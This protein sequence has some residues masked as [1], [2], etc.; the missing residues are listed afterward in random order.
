MARKKQIVLDDI[1]V[2]TLPFLSRTI[3]G[4]YMLKAIEERMKRSRKL[5]DS[6]PCQ[7]TLSMRELNYIGRITV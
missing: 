6:F 4:Q 3:L 7:L 1:D 2:T 5:E